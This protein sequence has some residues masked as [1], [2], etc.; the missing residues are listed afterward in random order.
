MSEAVLVSVADA[1]VAHLAAQTFSQTIEPQWSF[2]TW[3]SEQLKGELAEQLN[4][5]V[6]PV[7]T[8]QEAEQSTRAKVRF[9][10]PIDIAVRRRLGP[11]KQDDD[12]G[13]VLRDEIAALCLVVQE[14]HL[15]C[16]AHRFTDFS[17]GTWDSTKLLANPL[18]KHLI[19][20]RQFTGI[21]RVTF[22]VYQAFA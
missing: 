20:W 16:M 22:N 18:R 10:V 9:R 2:A 6:V 3:Q 7:T 15:A 11:T 21:V 5:D 12:T 13:K 1:V 19:D 4:V 8:S 14:L 17:A